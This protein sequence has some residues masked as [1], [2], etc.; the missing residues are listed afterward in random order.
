MS[1]MR[2][3][4]CGMYFTH[5][6][7]IFGLTFERLKRLSIREDELGKD[8]QIVVFCAKLDHIV[9]DQWILIRMLNGQGRNSG[10]TVLAK[11]ANSN[12]TDFD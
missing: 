9:K 8:D 1:A 4:S 3:L 11:F 7:I 5:T 6:R 10:A 12:R 2:W